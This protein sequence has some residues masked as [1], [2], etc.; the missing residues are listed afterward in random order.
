VQRVLALRERVPPALAE[1]A[2][3]DLGR[4]IDLAVTAT[5]RMD[6]LDAA[7][8]EQDLRN[9]SA[10]AREQLLERDAWAARLLELTAFLDAQRIRYAAA[11]T[12]TD[13]DAAAEL[14][15]LRVHIEA[16]EEVQSL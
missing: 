2:N 12:G 9:P 14:D 16:L 10:E 11:A 5:A 15:E 7:L 4:V 13:G 1:E 8:L 6:E 3:A